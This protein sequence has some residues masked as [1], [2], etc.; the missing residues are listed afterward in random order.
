MELYL[1]GGLVLAVAGVALINIKALRPQQHRSL[2]PVLV[3]LPLNE[4]YKKLHDFMATGRWR[5]YSWTVLEK[6]ENA[7]IKASLIYREAYASHDL[8]ADAIWN[9]DL[10]EISET[11]TDITWSCQLKHWCDQE[12]SKRLCI[13]VDKILAAAFEDKPPSE[14]QSFDV[15]KTEREKATNAPPNM[16]FTALCRAIAS[17]SPMGYRMIISSQTKSSCDV[18]VERIGEAFGQKQFKA[19]FRIAY[20]EGTPGKFQWTWQHAEAK[21]LADVESSISGTDSWINKT[22]D[23]I[24]RGK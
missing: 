1:V 10:K 23:A 14:I 18:G 2:D 4:A 5:G 11:H 19:T 13:A 9:I 16:A 20:H 22:I 21:T 8:R 24:W 3:P 6:S 17:N 15:D 12:T 7:Y